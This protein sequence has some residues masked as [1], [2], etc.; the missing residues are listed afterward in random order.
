MHI[1]GVHPSIFPSL[2]TLAPSEIQNP[3]M[4]KA[5][6]HTSGWN[7]LF[8]NLQNFV[9][10]SY[11]YFIN[12]CYVRFYIE[13]TLRNSSFGSTKW[14]DIVKLLEAAHWEGR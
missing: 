4:V 7:F 14:Y 9:G 8:I 13:S 2:W 6:L 3:Y 5:E 1:D 11:F 12:C 10:F